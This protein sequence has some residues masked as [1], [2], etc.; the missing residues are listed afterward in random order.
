[1]LIMSDKENKSGIIITDPLQL[2]TVEQSLTIDEQLLANTFKN[3]NEVK[4][5]KYIIKDIL[6]GDPEAAKRDEYAYLNLK[7]IKNAINWLLQN[8]FDE[9]LK[10]LLIEKPYLLAFKDKPPTPE[11]FL[12]EKYI[13]AMSES[14]WK[15]VR[16]RFCDYFNPMKP[17]RTAV[18]N[19]SI[20]SGKCLPYSEQISKVDTIE[21]DCDGNHYKVDADTFI[22]IEVCGLPDVIQA[23]D[24]LT[25]DD[26]ESIKIEKINNCK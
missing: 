8:D 5:L 26:L 12:T 4:N 10:S 20:G 25:R 11:E 15:P 2:K 17:F 21:F 18:L 1:M 24:L 19:P 23:K 16:K 9:G 22:E 14:V 7:Q 6:S 3:E 13:G